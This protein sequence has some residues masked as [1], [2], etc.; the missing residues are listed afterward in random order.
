MLSDNWINHP[1]DPGRE[2][3]REGFKGG[4]QDFHAAFEGFDIRRDAMVSE[5]DLVVCRITMSGRHVG[6]LG[7]WQPS[8]E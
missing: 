2:N 7:D 6:A 8:G 5:G 3:N 4:V 1:A